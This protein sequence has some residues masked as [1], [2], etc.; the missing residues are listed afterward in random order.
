MLCKKQLSIKSISRWTADAQ[1]NKIAPNEENVDGWDY[2]SHNRLL[3]TEKQCSHNEHQE[4]EK[5]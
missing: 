1:E 2:L 4:I 5:K 3:A